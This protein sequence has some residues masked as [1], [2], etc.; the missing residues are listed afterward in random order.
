MTWTTYRE[1]VKALSEMIV[2]AQKPIR[3]LN[4]IKWEASVEQEFFKNKGKQLP[5]VSPESYQAISLDF[6]PAK[7]RGE[8]QTIGEQIRKQLGESD[9]LG[10]LLLSITEQ[11]KKVVDMLEGRGTK[12]FYNVSRELYG[13]AS[14]RFF[15]TQSTIFDQGKLLYAILSS[16]EGKELGKEYPKTLS[17]QQVVEQLKVKFENS[18]LKGMIEVQI[19]DGIVADSAA[20]GDILKIKE[21]AHFSTKEIDIFEVHEGWV[22]IATNANGKGQKV[23][24]FL[25]KGPPKCAATQE[26]LAI[27]MEILT[28]STYP[29]RARSINDRILGVEQAEEGANFLEVYEFYLSEGYEEEEAFRNAM[30]I[31]RGG[32]IEGGGPFTKDLSYCKG[33]IE[34][35][36]FIRACIRRGRPELIPFL[37][38][39]KLHV[40][41]VPLLYRLHLEGVVDSPAFLPPQFADL[42]GLAVWMSFS[43]FL[44]QINSEQVQKH[45]DALFA[46]HL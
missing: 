43:S 42:S 37:F 22:H 9:E 1:K 41:D 30:R 40:D 11:Y 18:F 35:Y 26:G 38:A 25:A 46:K 32:C 23:A 28:F 7:K 21:G 5:Q 19:S 45:Y 34:N 15:D 10:G 36:N 39:G 24:K 33:Y 6:E 29:R 13:S 27:L 14:D 12:Q 31:F 44:N 2:E 4:A 3:I 8:L 16:L 20:G 17:A